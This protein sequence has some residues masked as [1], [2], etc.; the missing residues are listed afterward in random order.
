LASE[1]FIGAATTTGNA[2]AESAGGLMSYFRWQSFGSAMRGA[3]HFFWGGAKT[4][5]YGAQ[6]IA[7]AGQALWSLK[8]N[9]F[10]L[11]ATI[12]AAAFTIGTAAGNR[13][14]GRELFEGF[15]WRGLW[16]SALFAGVGGAAA[17]R[18][19]ILPKTLRGS[20][21]RAIGYALVGAGS[22]GGAYL[23]AH[24]TSGKQPSICGLS[25][26]AFYGTI[27]NQANFVTSPGRYTAVS[28]GLNTT[29]ETNF[30]PWFCKP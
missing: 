15:S 23:A 4:V 5:W 7:Y 24:W 21:G 13:F 10:V 18:F 20:M 16:T 30:L 19:S 9:A 1:A 6:T 28:I 27:A 3:G 11:D 2:L 22:S 29:T 25:R 8:T 26:S 14:A 17:E 12:G